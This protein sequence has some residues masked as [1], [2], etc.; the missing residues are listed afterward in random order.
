MTIPFPA[1]T[2][3][4]VRPGCPCLAIVDL[5]PRRPARLKTSARTRLS[6][7]PSQRR[8]RRVILLR[9]P[10]ATPKRALYKLLIAISINATFGSFQ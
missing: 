4:A 2:D 9:D 1:A 3:H 8:N 5:V 10:V 7:S 6:E